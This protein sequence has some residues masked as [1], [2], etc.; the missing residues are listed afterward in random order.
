MTN[1]LTVQNGF[2][3]L[4]TSVASVNIVGFYLLFLTS[5]FAAYG[6]FLSHDYYNEKGFFIVF[7]LICLVLA[8]IH[9]FRLHHALKHEITRWDIVFM[10]LFFVPALFI[11][12]Q[13][14]NTGFDFF[15]MP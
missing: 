1:T 3:V 10:C 2:K 9:L 8:A 6:L 4:A 5:A 14:M 11:V 13:F 12:L 15:F 7:G